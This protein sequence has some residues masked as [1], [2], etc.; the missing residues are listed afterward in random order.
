M[1]SRIAALI[2]TAYL[3]IVVGGVNVADAAPPRIYVENLS[4]TVTD[5]WV[6]NA[7]PAWQAAVSQ[8][9][10]SHWGVDAE[11]VLGA[12]PAGAE[13]IVIED[14]L[15]S[16]WCYGYHDVVGG[17]P[18]AFVGTEGDV[19][20]TLTHELFEMLADP[21]TTR[22]T[23]VGKRFYLDEVADPVE[24]ESYARPGAD[25]SAVTIS[26]FVN[27][28]YYRPGHVAPYDFLGLIKRPLQLL[29]GGYISWWEAGSWHQRFARARR[30]LEALSPDGWSWCPECA[31]E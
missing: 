15:P 20:V 24:N 31:Y 19:S 28:V 11:L 17:A 8:D 21:Y 2:I 16:C 22:F 3:V 4:A 23:K 13:K 29:P 6:A 1:I 7:L 14:Q 9:F 12:A 26:D 27:E 10:E 5:A 25:G 18:I 30:G